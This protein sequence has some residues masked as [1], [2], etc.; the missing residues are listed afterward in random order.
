MFNCG[1]SECMDYQS[2]LESCYN[3]EVKMNKDKDKQI[4][5]LRDAL[6]KTQK[7][8]NEAKLR[9]VKYLGDCSRYIK[10][11]CCFVHIVDT[12]FKKTTADALYRAIGVDPDEYR[13]GENK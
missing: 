11:I 9:T 8:L 2:I 6:S 5:E 12:K 4:K 13:F 1:N 3:S 10:T 7:E